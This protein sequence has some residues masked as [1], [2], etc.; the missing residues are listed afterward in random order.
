MRDYEF[1]L[2]PL[3]AGVKRQLRAWPS[4]LGRPDLERDRSIW[5]HCG[6]REDL[7]VD[8][9]CGSSNRL[10]SWLERVDALRAAT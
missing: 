2:R 8:Q 6:V 1:G 9:M 4:V 3:T 10:I 7:L 5:Q